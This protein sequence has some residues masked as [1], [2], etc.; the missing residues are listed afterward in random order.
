MNTDTKWVVMKVN[1]RPSKHGNMMEEVTFANTN[2]VAHTYLDQDNQNYARWRDIVDLHD[3][4]CGVIVKGLKP[5]PGKY[6]KQTTEP[7]INADS[8]VQIHH[9]ELDRQVVLKGL[10]STIIESAKPKVE[11]FK[12]LDKN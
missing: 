12:P 11:L 2:E 6:H 5:K 1:H 10:E 7:L 8:P 9:V 4:G 3:R